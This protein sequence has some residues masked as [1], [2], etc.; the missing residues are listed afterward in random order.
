MKRSQVVAKLTK[1][2]KT[3][4]NSKL[5]RETSRTILSMLEE[6]GMLPPWSSQRDLG[7]ECGCKGWCPK[8]YKWDYEHHPKGAFQTDRIYRR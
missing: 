1:L 8:G 3:Y 2:L 6:N 7:C 4:E 5:D